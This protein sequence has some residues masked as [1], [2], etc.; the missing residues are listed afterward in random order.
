MGKNNT[1]N[2]DSEAKELRRKKLFWRTFWGVLIGTALVSLV[3][4][5]VYTFLYKRAQEVILTYEGKQKEISEKVLEALEP[6]SEELMSKNTREFKK[7]LEEVVNARFEKIKKE[8]VKA[9]ADWFYSYTTSCKIIFHMVKDIT[10]R[11]KDSFKCVKDMDIEACKR[12]FYEG[13]TA[14]YIAENVK[15]YLITENDINFISENVRS[16]ALEYRQ[17]Y[18]KKYLKAFEEIVSEEMNSEYRN[19][20]NALEEIINSSTYMENFIQKF[21]VYLGSVLGVRYALGSSKKVAGKQVKKLIAKKFVTRVEEKVAQKVISSITPKFLAK[22]APSVVACIE[23]GPIAVACGTVVATAVDFIFHE[24][25]EIITRDD[26]EE[27]IREELDKI[28]DNLIE[29]ITLAFQK[30][31]VEETDILNKSVMDVLSK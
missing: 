2:I 20:A 16:L 10:S 17:K 18:I 31:L 26:F 15:K 21:S 5:G 11:A 25:D 24:I 6:K 22:F 27:E 14:E 30:T 7:E 29:G 12:I 13:S 19:L 4:V 8:N 23:T 1:N 28:R 9:F 3:V